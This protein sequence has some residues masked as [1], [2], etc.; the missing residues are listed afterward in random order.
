LSQERKKKEMKREFSEQFKRKS[1]TRM[2]NCASIVGLAKELGIHW[3]LL[4]KWKRRLEKAPPPSKEQE[5]QAQVD[6]LQ[7]ELGK[8][9]LEVSFLANALQK[10]QDRRGKS[11]GTF[12]TRSGK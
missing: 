9:T 5:L 8:K 11:G 6:R 4:Y 3:S 7:G 1:V 2:R 12:T 10:I